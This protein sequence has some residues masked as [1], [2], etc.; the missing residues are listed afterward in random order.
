MCTFTA[1]VFDKSAFDQARRDSRVVR[2]NR[3]HSSLEP[4]EV[5]H[6]ASEMGD[7]ALVNKMPI[8][9][10][11]AVKK[12]V[13]SLLSDTVRAQLSPDVTEQI[14][15]WDKEEKKEKEKKPANRS[16]GYIQLDFHMEN[17]V[18][19]IADEEPQ[20]ENSPFDAGKTKFG[21]STVVFEKETKTSDKEAAERLRPKKMPPIPPAKYE[22]KSSAIPKHSSDSQILYTDVSFGQASE[23]GSPDLRHSQDV[24]R[25]DPPYVNVSHRSPPGV[26]PAVPPRRGIAT[27]M[28]E[29]A[30]APIPVPRRSAATPRGDQNPQIPA[31]KIS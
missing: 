12:E 22:G 28:D 24:A 11:K 30:P 10:K 3:R 5:Q 6:V 14:D 21:Y 17:G 20:L 4:T 9:Q 1:Q 8:K 23:G 15:Q 13:A 25:K 18:Q 2:D 7:Y 27:P 16:K 29:Q 19:R 31:R 26:P